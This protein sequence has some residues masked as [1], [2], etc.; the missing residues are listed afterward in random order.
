MKKYLSIFFF[1]LLFTTTSYSKI[2]DNI[3]KNLMET[4]NISFIFSQKTGEIV[5]EG[6][7]IIVFPKKMKFTS[8]TGR[9]N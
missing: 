5:E 8:I 1:I 2:I 6:T 7:C 9:N 3:A 4:E